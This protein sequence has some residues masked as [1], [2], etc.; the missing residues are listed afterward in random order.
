MFIWDSVEIIEFAKHLR[1]SWRFR[2]SREA[3]RQENSRMWWRWCFSQEAG[4]LGKALGGAEAVPLPCCR[5]GHC[6]CVQAFWGGR[7][8]WQMVS[9]LVW[10]SQSQEQGWVG[11][12]REGRERWLTGPEMHQRARCVLGLWKSGISYGLHHNSMAFPFSTSATL[13]SFC[14]PPFHLTS[15]GHHCS[16]HPLRTSSEPDTLL[17]PVMHYFIQSLCWTF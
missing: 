3:V 16:H 2:E 10:G 15:H 9:S 6:L 4:L 17:G 7:T 5:W 12:A 13:F 11:Y 1:A 14:L 8:I